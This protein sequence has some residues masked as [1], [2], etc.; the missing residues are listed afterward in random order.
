MIVFLTSD[1][2]KFLLDWAVARSPIALPPGEGGRR[3][4]GEKGNAT[5]A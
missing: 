4:G 5:S 3:V 1:L 2:F